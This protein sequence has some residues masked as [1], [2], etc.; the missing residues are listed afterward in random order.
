MHCTHC[1]TLTEILVVNYVSL[2]LRRITENHVRE[3]T[4]AWTLI[5]LKTSFFSLQSMIRGL[6]CM[7]REYRSD[8]YVWWVKLY[9]HDTMESLNM[10][11]SENY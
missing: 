3:R 5:I 4:Y 10:K 2:L 8:F 9:L 6:Q 11:A 1:F 7:L